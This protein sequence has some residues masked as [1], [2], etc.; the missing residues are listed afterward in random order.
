MVH[1]WRMDEITYH[2]FKLR[3]PA[4]L[5]KRIEGEAALA[6]RSV[7][8]EIIYRLEGSLDG[9][10]G[11]LGLRAELLAK[12]EINQATVDML[13]RSLVLLDSMRNE[14]G[15]GP[16]PGKGSGMSVHEAMRD[17]DEAIAVY[18]RKVESATILLSEIA[19]AEAKGVAIDLG[20]VQQ[21]AKDAG[22]L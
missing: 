5:F 13:R 10:A 20:R 22:L 17:T 18:S 8:A 2:Q 15:A 1:N 19:I 6:N 16:Y 4:E 3:M 12:R 11:G 7:S 21:S 14:D 9:A